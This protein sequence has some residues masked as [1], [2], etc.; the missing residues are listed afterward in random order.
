MDGRGLEP[1]SLSLKVV[2]MMAWIKNMY[3]PSSIY[4]G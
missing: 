2:A 1:A 4:Q 3:R